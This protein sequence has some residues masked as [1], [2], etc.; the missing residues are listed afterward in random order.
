MGRRNSEPYDYPPRNHNG[1]HQHDRCFDQFGFL[2]AARGT[3]HSM[4][5]VPSTKPAAKQA[6]NRARQLLQSASD[7]LLTR[8][9]G[10]ILDVLRANQREAYH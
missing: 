3:T 2:V 5:T 10:L 7:S 6:Q 8:C 1:D 4:R 9:P